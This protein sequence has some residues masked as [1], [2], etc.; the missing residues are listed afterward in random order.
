MN[1]FFYF[2]KKLVSNVHTN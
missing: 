1:R 2:E